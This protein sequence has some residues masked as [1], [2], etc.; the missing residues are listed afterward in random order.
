MELKKQKLQNQTSKVEK[1][2]PEKEK[3]A[4][5]PQQG[6]N[7]DDDMPMLVSDDEDPSLGQGAIRKQFVGKKTAG[8]KLSYK[9]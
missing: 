3:T 9:K 2:Q 7:D 8:L 6:S 4:D 1:Q 5:Q